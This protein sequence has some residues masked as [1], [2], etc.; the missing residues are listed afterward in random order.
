MKHILLCVS[1]AFTL[2]SCNPPS[3]KL[4]VYGNKIARNQSEGGSN[5][6]DSVDYTIPD[7]NFW[8]QDSLPV[9]IQLID[10]KIWVVDFFFTA[11]PSIC[12]KM[13][14]EMLRVY[15]KYEADSN[16]V[17]LSFSIDP[18]RDSVARLHA[19]A[20]KLGINS[21]SKWHLLTGDKD[22]IY[23]IA[24]KFLVSAEEDPDAPGG[25]VHSGNFILVDKQR[26]LR[27]YYDGVKTE[28]VDQL[29]L[30]IDVLK[31]EEN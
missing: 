23:S 29:L 4:P 11:C 19:Y 3:E 15:D 24:E 10:G 30:D 6:M 1:I 8:N 21:S 7:F 26:R 17:I 31:K 18:K 22:S 2:Y 20:S 28:S 12:P 5:S 14:K 9:N 27:G 13:K 25:H 16:L